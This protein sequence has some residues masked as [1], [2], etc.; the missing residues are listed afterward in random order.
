MTVLYVWARIRQKEFAENRDFSTA[1]IIGHSFPYNKKYNDPT[2]NYVYT[3]I[4]FGDQRVL[5][6]KFQLKKVGKEFVEFNQD[7]KTQTTNVLN[8]VKKKQQ[9]NEK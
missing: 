9:N 1:R 8:K 7:R 3:M 5:S 2:F 4:L 6:L